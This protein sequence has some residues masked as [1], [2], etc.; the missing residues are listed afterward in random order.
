MI[1]HSTTHPQALPQGS[2]AH[3]FYS[4]SFYLTGLSPS[5]VTW[6]PGDPDSGFMEKGSKE[7]QNKTKQNFLSPCCMSGYK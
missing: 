6:T 2:L 1:F 5:C 7:L 4:F 3:P